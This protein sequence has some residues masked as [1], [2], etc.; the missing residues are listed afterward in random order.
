MAFS[1]Q[2]RALQM[3]EL[4]QRIFQFSEPEDNNANARVCKTWS[5][6]ALAILWRSVMFDVVLDLLGPTTRS[7]AGE[8]VMWSILR[9]DGNSF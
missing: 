1:S 3:P 2:P 8:L 5:N 6:E 7:A 4:L 9:V